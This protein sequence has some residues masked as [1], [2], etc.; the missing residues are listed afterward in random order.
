MLPKLR[1]GLSPVWGASFLAIA[2]VDLWT[3]TFTHQNTQLIFAAI[4][5]LVGFSHLMGA[6]LVVDDRTI[7]L[8]NP[9]GMTLKTFVI[10]SPSELEIQGRKLFIT[11]GGKRKKISGLMANG[12]QWRE[13]AAAIKAAK[14]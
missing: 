10:E 8:K 9:L 11:S 3:Y 13:L 5:G 6:L 7:E 12:T 4:M 14:S 1:V 2:G